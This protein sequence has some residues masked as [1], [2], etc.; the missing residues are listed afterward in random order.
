MPNYL[1]GL[2][3]L[4]TTNVLVSTFV[5]M[6]PGSAYSAIQATGTSTAIL[7]IAQKGSDFPSGILP[8]YAGISDTTFAAQPGESFM[9]YDIGDVCD[10]WIGAGGCVPGSLLTSDANGKGII[11]TTSQEVGAIALDFGNSGDLTA[12]L[13]ICRKA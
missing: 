8:D 6:D 12:V 1:S 10:L 7:G 3:L 11:A 5:N 9:V 2:P 13:S 4:A